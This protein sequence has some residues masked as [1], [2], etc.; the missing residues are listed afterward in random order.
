MCEIY[1]VGLTD[2]VTNF[3]LCILM[4]EPSPI[5]YLDFWCVARVRGHVSAWYEL[6][7][8]IHQGGYMSLIKYTAF[9]NSL[10][11]ALQRSGFCCIRRI[12]STPVG[13]A[14]DL[15]TCS[16][17][18]RKLEW[19]LGI[20]YRHGCKW[21]YC[22][23]A[24]KS[25]V[26]VF[27]ETPATNS[28]NA[29]RRFFMLGDDRVRE[30]LSYEHVGVVCCLY[31]NDVS[32][33]EKRLSKA[34]RALNAVSGLGI[35]RNGLTVATCSII[36]WVVVAPIAL[37]GSEL[38]ILNDRSVSL[39]ESFQNYAGKRV[40]RLFCRSPNSFS[41]YSLGWLRLERLVEVKKLL[42]VRAI[43]SLEVTEPSRGSSVDVLRIF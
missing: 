40:Q 6:K 34:R 27:G 28:Y 17:T 10:I 41:F 14:D 19:A 5:S 13:Y 11:V 9:I 20:V 25:G 38:W 42:F 8:G 16:M 36:F 4:E 29:D 21:R 18:E 37:F 31:E 7:W 32:G 12:P 30:K 26:M 35:R 3:H 39:I 2:R 23:N 33:I 22:F 24:K 1:Q 15:A 43:L